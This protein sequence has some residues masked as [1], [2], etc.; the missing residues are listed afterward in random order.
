MAM[1]RYQG[2]DGQEQLPPK[3]LTEG[4]RVSPE[5][6]LHFLGNPSLS[7]KDD[8]RNGVRSYLQVRMPTFSLSENELGKLVR[9]FQ[10]LA[11][12]PFPY[13][14]DDVPVLSAKETEMARSLFSSTAAPCLK[15][16]AT[17]DPAHDRTATAPNFLQARGRLKPDWMERWI[18]DPQAISPGTSMPSG[19]FKRQNNHWVFSGPTPPS[20]QGYDKDQTRLLVD[21]ILQLTPEEQRRVSA[22]MGH[23]RAG[24]S[25]SNGSKPARGAGSS[26][27]K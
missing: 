8:N 13:I 9:F 11:R 4:A 24:G 18:I 1:A 21:Y 27:S 16:H 22:A 2:A 19:L 20:F 10:A 25:A 15:C 3:L 6:M 5:W 7:E 17:G 14:P 26:G 23:A 12:Q